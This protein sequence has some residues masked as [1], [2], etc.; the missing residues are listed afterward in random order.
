MLPLPNVDDVGRVES[1]VWPMH[2][3]DLET[4]LRLFEWNGSD[5]FD[6]LGVPLS[7]SVAAGAQDI[8]RVAREA[9]GIGVAVTTKG[10]DGESVLT[11]YAVSGGGFGPAGDAVHIDGHANFLSLE[12]DLVDVEG[13]AWDD[14][15]SLQHKTSEVEFRLRDENGFGSSTTLAYVGGFVTRSTSPRRPATVLVPNPS[16]PGNTGSASLRSR[17]ASSRSGRG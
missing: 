11:V 14:L 4:E 6:E 17:C 13:D 3:I 7:I 10:E 9:D 15:V 5:G 8:A 16:A 2:R 12:F 1:V